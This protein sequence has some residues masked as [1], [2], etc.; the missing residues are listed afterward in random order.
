MK[1]HHETLRKMLIIVGITPPENVAEY[2]DA[3]FNYEHLR[4]IKDLLGLGIARL[5]NCA[6][7]PAATLRRR[8]SSDLFTPKESDALYRAVVVYSIGLVLAG[9]DHWKAQSWIL[10]EFNE[11]D[12]MAPID[13]IR[14][15]ALTDKVEAV[16]TKRKSA[17][18]AI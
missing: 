10:Q 5:A 18:R 12:G 9:G 15:S 2:V 4:N 1:A 17:V 13:C 16:F 11:L 7:I 8:K 3:G 6:D 14:L